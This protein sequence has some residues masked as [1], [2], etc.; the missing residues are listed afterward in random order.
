[1]KKTKINVYQLVALLAIV[2][3][4]SS[5]SDQ[6]YD[7]KA[8]ERITPDQHYK[9]ITDASNS[10]MGAFAPLREIMPQ[11]IMLDGLR[12]DQM[13]P[14]HG[15]DGY[16][17]AINRQ[18]FTLD[19]PYIDA[20]AYYKVIINCNEV[21][22][23]IH[24]VNELDR[25]FTPFL[26]N[27][28][29]GALITLRGWSYLTLVKLYGEAAWI[30]GTYSGLPVGLKQTFIT[31]DA[32]IDTLIH[33]LTPY[34]YDPSVGKEFV[35]FD[36]SP[37]MNTK[38][39]LGELYL[40]KSDYVNA[41]KYLKLACESFL[42][43]PTVFKVDKA[44][45]KEA[46]KNIFIGAEYQG[47]ENLS[48]VS[49]NLYEN[50][51]NPLP[52]WLMSSDLYLV[53]PA[54]SLVDSF[55][56]QIQANK[57]IGDLYRGQSITYDTIATGEPYISKYSLDKGQEFST[58]IVITRAADLHLELA[59]AL[60]RTGNPADENLALILLNAG[61]SNEKTKPTAYAK[62]SGNLG[63]RGRAY[64]APKVV[65][66]SVYET[67]GVV[68]KR[69]KL[70]GIA[71]TEYIEDLIMSE[72]GMELAFE[73]HRWFDLVRVAN[74]RGKPEYLADKV[75]SKFTDPSMAEQVKSKLMIP[76][77]WYLPLKK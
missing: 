6:F 48:Y 55:K 49:Y 65:P 59:E 9:S 75:A 29:K 1:M 26:L 40:E 21:L 5:C 33:Q 22:A 57:K 34:V 25:N 28:F 43:Q 76:A 36:F 66:D 37:I 77:N 64:L 74:R 14:G 44:Y 56:V 3:A 39:V 4:I 71:R 63:I 70:E 68:G 52:R 20:S 15:S 72:R 13:V 54:Q 53:K 2:F 60:N 10:A 47:N 8:G 7:E 18:E 62:W 58:D 51:I 42:N 27:T 50:Q 31:K 19:N 17:E 69:V 61:F 67:P 30:D 35:E 73:G 41:V 38:A 32:M 45:T 16:L 46:W 24:K 12:S 23:N 11:M